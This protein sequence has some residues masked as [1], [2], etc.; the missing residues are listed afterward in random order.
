MAE[1]DSITSEVK[2]I[3]EIAEKSGIEIRPGNSGATVA[4]GNE[5]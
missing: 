2:N 5:T 3:I 1:V 4:S